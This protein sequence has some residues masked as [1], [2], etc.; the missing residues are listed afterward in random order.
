MPPREP[1][2][3]ERRPRDRGRRRGH[4]DRRSGSGDRRRIRSPAVEGQ[5]VPR[6]PPR[7]GV[8]RRGH[9][10]RCRDLAARQHRIPR[11]DRI[12]ALQRRRRRRAL[13]HRVPL[14]H[15]RPRA[16]RGGAL[17][18]VP[19]GDQDARRA[20]AGHPDPGPRRR[21][22]HPGTGGGARTKSVPRL[23]LDPLLAAAPE[24]V[25]DAASG[26]PAGRHRRPG[27]GHVPAGLHRD[28]DPPGEDAPRRRRRGA[29][30]GGDS[31]RHR[32][33]HRHDGRSALGGPDGPCVLQRG[34][35][36]LDRDERPHPVHAGGRSW[37]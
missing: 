18:G 5:R 29:R 3:G 26:D 36:L 30:R 25:Q 7:N 24:G 19:N 32:R 33:L 8:P 28:G 17:R 35:I 37:E 20:S 22:V 13:P 4:R 6:R 23:P 9:H 11:R 16:G 1:G 12:R 14:P 2:R 21:Q 27:E 15:Q 34:G 10:R 31:P